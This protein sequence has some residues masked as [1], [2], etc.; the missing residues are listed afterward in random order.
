MNRKYISIC[1]LLSLLA[2]IAWAQHIITTVAGGGPN[3]VPALQAGIS[4][5]GGFHTDSLGNLYIVATGANAIYKIDATGTLTTVVGN[6]TEGFSGDGGPA[7]PRNSTARPVFMW[8]W[9]ETFSL[10]MP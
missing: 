1:T 2:P 6:G 10:R 5:P 4:G 9:P 3:N 7:T 8:T